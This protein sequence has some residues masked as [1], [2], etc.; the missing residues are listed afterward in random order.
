MK[1]KKVYDTLITEGDSVKTK[2]GCV[3]LFFKPTDE[4]L[5]LQDD[6]DEEDVHSKIVDEKEDYGRTPDDEYHVTVLY[7]LH[8][9]V[10][11]EQVKEVL[12]SEDTP[13]VEFKDITLFENDDFDVV[14]IDMSSKGLVSLNKKLVEYPHTTNY[15]DYHPHTTLAYVKAGEGK[16]Y[17][18]KLKDFF[19]EPS[20]FIYSKIDGSKVKIP[21]KKS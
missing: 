19:V 12:Y 3:M 4:L 10:T 15:P 16:K 17:T 2:Y 13:E 18:K 5:S 9:E 11:D 20:H 6:I 1:L 8:E 7:G 14:K 21:F